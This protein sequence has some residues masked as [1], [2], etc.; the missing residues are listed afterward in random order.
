VPY[1]D[2]EKRK[3]YGRD[4]QVAYYA[5]NKEAH[6]QRVRKAEK[7]RTTRYKAYINEL[8]SKPC[9]DCKQTFDPV[10]MDFD[11][12]DGSTKCFNVSEGVTRAGRGWE[13][14]LAEVAK[15]EVVCACC[16]R[17]RTKMRQ[18]DRQQKSDSI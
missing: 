6:I 16:H 8:K 5:T 13:A 10:C 7:E 15:C 4:Y 14:I 18:L 12:L 2:P 3:A 17:L 9:V 11:H 1:K